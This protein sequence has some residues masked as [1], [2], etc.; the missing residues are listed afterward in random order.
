MSLKTVF[1]DRLCQEREP[2][3][4]DRRVSKVLFQF[5]F[6]LY[7]CHKA[8]EGYAMQKKRTSLPYQSIRGMAAFFYPKMEIRGYSP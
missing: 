5:I 7:N 2:P 8:E 1:S 4:C 3:W 6:W